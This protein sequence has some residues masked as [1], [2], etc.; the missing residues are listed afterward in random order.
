MELKT[1]VN[2][3]FEDFHDTIIHYVIMDDVF[4]RN[5]EVLEII[6]RES[7]KRANLEAIANG[8][9]MGMD[10]NITGQLGKLDNPTLILVGREDDL[11]SQNL[12]DIMKD[13]IK[14]SS[15]IVF[16]DT[17]HNLLVGENVSEILR[18]IRKFI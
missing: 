11:I 1:A 9:D 5:R 15:I 14:N 3:S 17:K 16:D 6:K 13:N 18:L 7:A 12:T 8:I 2:N 10:L 4:N